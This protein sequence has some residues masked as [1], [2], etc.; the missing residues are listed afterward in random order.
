MITKDIENYDD[1]IKTVN[2][3]SV[4]IILIIADWCKPCHE[5]KPIIEDYIYKLDYKNIIYLRLNYDIFKTDDRFK[6]KMLIEGLPSF[7]IYYMNEFERCIV[8]D[9]RFITHFVEMKMNQ[10]NQKRSIEL[11]DDF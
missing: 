3:N 1:L 4:S 10:I 7:W 9:M 11:K 5:L 6:E 8:A 2:E